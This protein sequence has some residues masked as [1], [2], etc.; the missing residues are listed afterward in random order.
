VTFDGHPVDFFRST[1]PV[2]DYT[3]SDENSYYDYF[4]LF[5]PQYEGCIELV[6]AD[7]YWAVL[8]P[9]G[10]WVARPALHGDEFHP[11]QP[12]RYVA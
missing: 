12:R 4:G 8:P 9:P 10:C 5:D 7:G 3:V 1:S 6:V 11:L 2:F